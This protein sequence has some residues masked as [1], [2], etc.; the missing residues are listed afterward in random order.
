M[1]KEV[2]CAVYEPTKMT[3]ITQQLIVGDKIRVGG[4]V[5]K[6]TKNHQRILNVEFLKIL[7]LAKDSRLENPLCKKC[8]KKM[9]SKGKNQGFQCIKCQKKVSDKITHEIP[10]KLTKKLYLP[11]V[12]AHR[13]LTRPLQRMNRINQEEKFDPTI[14]WYHQYRN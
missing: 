14:P 2:L 7:K 5:R 13:P 11:A 3:L 4:G 12:S 8:N 6:A 1:D 9:K 10:R